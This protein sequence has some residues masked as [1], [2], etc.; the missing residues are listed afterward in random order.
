[1]EL[2]VEAV[3]VQ[4]VDDSDGTL[5]FS[6]EV[7]DSICATLKMETLV[8]NESLDELFAAIRQALKQLELD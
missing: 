6:V 3:K 7:F 5:V 2:K 8:C 1:M 4:C